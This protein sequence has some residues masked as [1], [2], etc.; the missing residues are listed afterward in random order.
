[1]H[2]AGWLVYVT[3]IAISYGIPS[4]VAVHRGHRNAEAI[5]ALNLFLGWTFIAWAIALVWA[6]TDNVEPAPK[7]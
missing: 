6:C 4:A 2:I 3:V 7:N 5:V 1:M